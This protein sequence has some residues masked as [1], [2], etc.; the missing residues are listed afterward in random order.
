MPTLF[1]N[2]TRMPTGTTHT[3]AQTTPAPFVTTRLRC[4]PA[5]ATFP[6]PARVELDPTTQLAVHFD[7][8]GNAIEN[9]EH[10]TNTNTETSTQTS[11]DG[12]NGNTDT[13]K[14]QNS[15]Q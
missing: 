2:S 12:A 5:G 11:S 13:A 3:E 10:G 7:T 9:G 15:D 1:A 8:A 6:A 14:D 4:Y